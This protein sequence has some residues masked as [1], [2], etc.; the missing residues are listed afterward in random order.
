[1]KT[2]SFVIPVYNEEKRLDK[3]FTALEELVLPRGLKLNQVIFVN[4]GSTDKTVSLIKK[5]PLKKSFDI[6]LV[7]YKTNKGKGF[8]IRQG[9]LESNA[10][11]TLFFDA[12]M[13]T[14]L[15]QLVK[16]LPFMERGTD[17]IIGT[18]KNGHSTVIVHQPLIREMMG[19]GFTK[20]TRILLRSNVTDFTCGF[21]A[22]SKKAVQSIFPQSAINGW[23]YDAEIL[24]LAAK[25]KFSTVEVPVAWSD[26]KRTKVSLFKAVPST[27]LEIGTI[28]YVHSLSKSIVFT[29]LSLLTRFQTRVMGAK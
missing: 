1:M 5:S 28:M 8:A 26:D 9:M 25:N 7:T 4:D 6:K 15:T 20:V 21:K 17:V 23:G 18:R 12:D 3:T 14:P 27:L 16:L 11:Y 22:F 13:S 10:D 24:Y 29:P 19:R 2:I